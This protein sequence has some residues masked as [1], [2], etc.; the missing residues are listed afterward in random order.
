M[1]QLYTSNKN[2][3]T[4]YNDVV[5]QRDYEKCKH[6]EIS[7]KYDELVMKVRRNIFFFFIILFCFVYNFVFYY[8]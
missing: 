1:A 2:L 3:E 8:D 4:Q 7:V 5:K 6:D